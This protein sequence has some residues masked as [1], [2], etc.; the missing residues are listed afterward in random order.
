MSS[1]LS[2]ILGT[3][4]GA[5]VFHHDGRDY[6]VSHLT[7]AIKKKF[8]NWLKQNAISCLAEMRDLLPAEEY[9]REKAGVLEAAVQGRFGYHGK[10]AVE[11]LQTP[12]GILQQMAL[13]FGCDESE[14]SRLMMERTEEVKMI[15]DVIIRESLPRTQQSATEKNA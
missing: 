13:L 3:K 6:H 4:G 14:M 9:E 7:Q 15:A 8:E 11:A 10:L 12:A 2:S 1:D 5:L